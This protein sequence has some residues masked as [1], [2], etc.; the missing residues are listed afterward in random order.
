MAN[1]IGI[2][3]AIVIGVTAGIG[4]NGPEELVEETTVT[5]TEVPVSST[6]KRREVIEIKQ[7]T[8]FDDGEKIILE[9][10]DKTTETEPETT[11]V[12][13]EKYFPL[14]AVDGEML[15]EDLQEFLW[16][17]LSRYGLGWWMPYAMLQMYQES[18]FNRYDITNNL[19]YGILQYRKQYWPEKA[20]RYGLEGADIFNPYAQIHV[21]VQETKKRLI[22]FGL[23]K[24][25]TISRHMMSDYSSYNSKYVDDVFSHSIE[26][27]R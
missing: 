19:D 25:E 26:Q 9:V 21:Y 18:R 8:T 17:E 11:V 12:E 23:D 2:A 5:S 7:R 24:Y 10:I 13:T 20:A 22:D 6:F 3:I 1:L 4:G 14:Y 16:D 27:L 15:E